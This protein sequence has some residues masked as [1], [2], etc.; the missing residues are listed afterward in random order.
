MYNSHV[1]A[2]RLYMFRLEQD[3]KQAALKSLKL[4][5]ENEALKRQL[6]W[7]SFPTCS[8]KMIWGK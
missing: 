8:N 4:E 2:Y 7:L 3:M 5:L 6:A 1:W